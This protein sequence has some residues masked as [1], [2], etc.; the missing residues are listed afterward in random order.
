[1]G[2]AVTGVGAS[3]R[4]EGAAFGFLYHKL[5]WRLAGL[6]HLPARPR[7]RLRLSREDEGRVPAVARPA[8]A[9]SL[10]QLEDEHLEAQ[11]DD[12]LAKI[13]RVG[14]EGLTEQERQVLLRASDAITR[15]RG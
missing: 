3:G 5:G 10:Y 1:R 14:M 15:R 12:I 9:G 11:V 13:P 6:I 4:L 8:P 2:R 7:P